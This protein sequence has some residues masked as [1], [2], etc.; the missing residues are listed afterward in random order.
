MR[1]I[2]TEQAL[3]TVKRRFSLTPEDVREG[4]RSPR[5]KAAATL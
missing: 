1:K 3:K 4:Q 5:E 2:R